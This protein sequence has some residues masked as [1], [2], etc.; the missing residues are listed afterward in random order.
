MTTS[1]QVNRR[2][3]VRRGH[4]R[5]MLEYRALV[6]LSLPLC[7]VAAIAGRLAGRRPD[8]SGQSVF[9]QARSDAHAAI[10]YAFH[11]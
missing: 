1:S 8:H 6:A 11:G 3:A 7:L 10:G 2:I 4:M 5:D 9:A